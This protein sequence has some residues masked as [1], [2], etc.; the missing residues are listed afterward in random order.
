MGRTEQDI[1]SIA[2]LGLEGAMEIPI[3]QAG[4]LKRGR[5]L[6]ISL[7]YGTFAQKLLSDPKLKA[8]YGVENFT[9]E[10][11]LIKRYFNLAE[12][13]IGKL[14]QAFTCFENPLNQEEGV[15]ELFKV[16]EFQPEIEGQ[17]TK[18]VSRCEELLLLSSLSV[19]NGNR[20]RIVSDLSTE[21]GNLI[22]PVLGSFEDSPYCLLRNVVSHNGS[23]FIIFSV[24][25]ADEASLKNWLRQ[26]AR[27]GVSYKIVSF[28]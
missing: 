17:E 19:S 1:P 6:V 9:E 23:S 28:N 11:E 4:V 26:S 24:L 25:V 16:A 20:Q 8:N 15:L 18:Y 12:M 21:K 3:L 27:S 2:K 14:R 13:T 22:Y 5:R 7:P 10:L